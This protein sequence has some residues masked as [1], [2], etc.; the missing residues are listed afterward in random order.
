M[1][2]PPARVTA[3]LIKHRCLEIHQAVPARLSQHRHQPSFA[4][5]LTTR[6]RC[7]DQPIG[8][9]KHRLTIP[10]AIINKR[11]DGI[12]L[13]LEEKP[14]YKYWINSGVY[15]LNPSIF[16]FMKDEKYKDMPDLI[17]NVKAAGGRIFVY[18]IGDYWLDMG[19]FSDY[20]RAV[21]IID[22][23]KE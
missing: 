16:E 19:Q 17:E 6:I 22:Q 4:E 3:N 8:I 15:I 10:Y 14:T 9:K 20:E 7:L 21:E 12:L 13:D 5:L 11:K 1:R 2:Q 18:D 23:W